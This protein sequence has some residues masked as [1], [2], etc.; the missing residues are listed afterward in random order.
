MSVRRIGLVFAQDRDWRVFMN[1]ALN[2]RVSQVMKL[3][4]VKVD[5]IYKLF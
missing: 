1:A 2:P 5:V 3:A 4:L